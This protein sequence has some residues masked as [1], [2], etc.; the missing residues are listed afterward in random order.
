MAS[1]EPAVAAPGVRLSGLG[2]ARGRVTA[3]ARV[4]AT[5]D[6]AARLGRGEVLV[7]GQT[8]PGWAPLFFV[9]GA[10]VMERGGLLSHGAIVAREFGIPAVLD[11]RDACRRVGDGSTVTVDGTEGWV[12]VVA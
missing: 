12:E 2:S 7:T 8:D 11:V 1:G 9:A 4:V 6:E 3:A 5:L 10:L